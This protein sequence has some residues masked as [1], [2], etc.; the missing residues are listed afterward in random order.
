MQYYI[1]VEG[2]YARYNQHL[3]YQFASDWIYLFLF[4]CIL[5]RWSY[6]AQPVVLIL[7]ALRRHRASE[8]FRHC[9]DQAR[10]QEIALL[11]ALLEERGL[12][13]LQYHRHQF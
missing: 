10:W 12:L 6:G 11:H 13:C 5:R 3:Q 8:A 1:Q 9:R 7:A 2:P 4:I